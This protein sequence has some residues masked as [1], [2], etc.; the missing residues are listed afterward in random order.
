MVKNNVFFHFDLALCPICCYI[1]AFRGKLPG[2]S[3]VR[4][5]CIPPLLSIHHHFI[6]SLG[7]RAG[8]SLETTCH[9]A[10]SQH[11][12]VPVHRHH[13]SPLP[14]CPL[15]APNAPVHFKSKSFAASLLSPCPY[16]PGFPRHVPFRAG[17]AAHSHRSILLSTFYR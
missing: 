15:P 1:N 14:L 7:R 10:H 5:P 4:S 13:S 9:T 2:L 6:P 16:P 11:Q 12:T 3:T 17:D 8:I